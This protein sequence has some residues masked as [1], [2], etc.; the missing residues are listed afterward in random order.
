MSTIREML[1]V[2]GSLEKA[3]KMAQKFIKE[4]GPEY[5]LDLQLLYSMQGKVKKSW[6]V[7]QEATKVFPDDDRVAYDRG[8]HIMMQG[9]LL[10]GFTLMNRG[11]NVETW[12][13]API[14]SIRPIWNGE[15][16]KGK[17][18]LFN[19][20]AGFGDEITFIRFAKEITK[21]GAHVIVVCSPDLAPLF[22][23]IP[24]MSAVVQRETALGVYHDYWVPSMLAPVVLKTQFSDLSGKPYLEPNL[25][26]VKKFNIVINSNKLKVGIRWL[27]REGED[28]INRIFSKELFFDAVTQDHIQL[29]SLQKDHNEESLPKHI[30]DLEPMLETW[31]DTAGAIANLDLVVSSCTS[32]AHLAAA[33]GKPTWVIPPLMMYYVWSYPGNKSPWYDSIT[34]FRQEKYDE[35]EQPFNKMK[36]ELNRVRTSLEQN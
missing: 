31:E 1:E 2:A 27:G 11:R 7:C 30:V 8:W 19:C 26:H 25:K 10:G 33:M 23:R 32:V 36:E 5:L 12:G 35:W 4:K 9:D 34:L 28:Y 15:D 29:Y 20:E 13:N 17:H 16:I 6:E 3:E 24:E 18:I 22:A 21:L 14:G